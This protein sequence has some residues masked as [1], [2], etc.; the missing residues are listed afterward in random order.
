MINLFT[1]PMNIVDKL[2]ESAELT[3]RDILEMFL[4]YWDRE[5]KDEAEYAKLRFRLNMRID[6]PSSYWD[7]YEKLLNV[8][9]D[10][11]RGMA[12]KLDIQDILDKYDL[13]LP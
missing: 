12:K 10:I 7:K 5:L 2:I 11:I 3:D 13:E 6:K 4:A 1:K 8:R 9:A